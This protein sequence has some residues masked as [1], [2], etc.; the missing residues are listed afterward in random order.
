MAE[1][2]KKEMAESF[3]N[4]A[5]NKSDEAKEHLKKFNYPESIS[6]SQECRAF[7]K[8]N[9]YASSRKISQEV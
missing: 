3:L 5:W 4:G 2:P 9:F 1:Q 6:A 8:S 7:N